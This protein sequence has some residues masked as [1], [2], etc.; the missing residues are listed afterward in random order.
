MD[1][2]EASEFI[3]ALCD[4]EVIGAA[5]AEHIDSCASC[6]IRLREYLALGVELR[7]L[8]SV[9]ISE[10]A[11][12]PFQP[13]RRRVSLVLWIKSS[14][15]IRVPRFA[16]ALLL[17]VIVVLGLGWTRQTVRAGTR[18]SVLLVQFSTGAGASHFCALSSLDRKLD[19]C[20]GEIGTESG[21]LLWGLQLLSKDGD[22]AILGVRVRA[23][24]PHA[25]VSTRQVTE[26]PQQVYA[27]TPTEEVGLR[28]N[29][30]GTM[31]ISAQ[32]ID[33]V[34][35]VPT[36]SIGNN[37]DLDPG[38]DELR[39]F[40]PLLLRGDHIVGDLRGASTSIDDPE[41]VVDLYFKGTGRFILSLTPLPGSVEA[42]AEFNRLS[43]RIDG[44]VW[45]LISGAPI[46]RTGK[47]WILRRSNPPSR[48]SDDGS[49]LEVMR[50]G[51]LQRAQRDDP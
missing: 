27:V 34:P 20:A 36:G 51:K 19:S 43:F 38:P 13:A 26:I 21:V 11:V 25:G 23:E 47:L 50:V 16:F 31:R 17:A 7:R 37:H 48:N 49:Y 42:Q 9:E 8:A 46:T 30:F 10:A 18:G 1:C 22:R 4:G 24:N 40:S 15:S 44:D 28:V 35:S 2:D 39:L 33:H 6:G 45:K 32:W 29:G 12:A 3:S 5:A 14:K 41:Q